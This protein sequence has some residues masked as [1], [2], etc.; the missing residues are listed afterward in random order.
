MRVIERRL[1]EERHF[2]EEQLGFMP[3]KGT[4][5]AIFALRQVK[6]KHREIRKAF[7]WSLWF[8]RRPMTVYRVRKF[9]DVLRENGIPENVY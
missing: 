1:R 3:R 5:D 4:T 9:G 8:W 7:I 6:E 2:G